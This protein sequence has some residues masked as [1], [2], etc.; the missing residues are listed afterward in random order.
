MKS[1]ILWTCA[2]AVVLWTGAQATGQG[3]GQGKGQEKGDAARVK[4]NVPASNP[5]PQAPQNA[6]PSL[7]RPDKE[8][9]ALQG[10]KDVVDAGKADAAKGKKTLESTG[11]AAKGKGKEHQQQLSAL[12]KQFRHAQAKQLERQARLMRIRELAQQK[13]DAETV[14]RVDKLIAKQ[15]EVFNRKQTHLQGQKRA[16]QQPPAEGQAAPVTPPAEVPAQVE[17]PRPA[18]AGNPTN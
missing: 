6:A 11:S 2:L 16:T 8:K 7:G 3:K 5:A 17:T 14:T 9:E 4:E 15:N 1:S 12:D 10:G 13:G 18:N